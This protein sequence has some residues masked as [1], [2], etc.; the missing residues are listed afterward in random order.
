M[1]IVKLA[2]SPEPFGKLPRY[3]LHLGC[4]LL[5]TPAISL[6][7]GLGDKDLGLEACEAMVA[8]AAALDGQ[9]LRGKL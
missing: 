5:K 8:I 3:R 9:G 2:S 6:S 4:I 7:T 1:V